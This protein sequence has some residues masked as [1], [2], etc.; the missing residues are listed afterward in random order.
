MRLRRLL[1]FAALA[2]LLGGCGTLRF[3]SQAV[4]GEM[5][6]L[7]RA[8]SIEQ[9]LRSDAVPAPL[10]AKL[11]AVLRI[12]TFASRELALPD[13]DSYK[14]YS[15]LGRPY[16]VWNVFAA[17]EFSVKPV[18]SCFLFAGC[19][20]YRGYFNTADAEAEGAAL[21]QRGYDVFIGGVPAYSTLG[22][23]DDPVL[24]TFIRYPESELARLIFH[25]LAHQ[26]LYVK[27]DTLFNESFAVT[28]EQVGVQRWLAQNGN[29][30]ERATYTRME[31]M[32]REFVALILKYQGILGT[33][34]PTGH[35]RGAKAPGQGAALCRNGRRVP[36]AQG[37][38]GR[39]R[40]L[41]PL[42]LRQAQQRDPR[43]GGALHRTGAGIS[44]TAGARR[45]RF[46][47]FLRRGERS[48]QTAQG[49]T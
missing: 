11:R 30:R 21:R 46:A 39:V 26:L 4:R 24:S 25:E 8:T 32:R 37:I 19:V 28:V 42:V 3:Y 31:A 14:R 23:F 43:L 35:P 44:R 17:P 27:D 5:Q 20:D 34:L 15:D 36:A 18:T 9:E 6:V 40:R 7:H 48:G 49:R 38:M 1:L 13:N 47:A 16:V 22:W 29:E 41:R 12:R 45:R 33:V 2:P 10:K